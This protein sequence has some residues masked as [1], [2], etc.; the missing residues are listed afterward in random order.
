MIHTICLEMARPSASAPDEICGHTR[1]IPSGTSLEAR[2]PT[3]H[4]RNTIAVTADG[5]RRTRQRHRLWRRHPA[6]TH[7]ATPD[8]RK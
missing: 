6:D 1:R 7:G 5:T 4:P 2:W 3:D 8:F